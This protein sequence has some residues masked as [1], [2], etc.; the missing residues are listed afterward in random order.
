[1]DSAPATREGDIV[2]FRPGVD[3]SRVEGHLG[4]GMV[5]RM[6]DTNED[7]NQPRG[8]VMVYKSTTAS[9]FSTNSYWNTR[10]G[11][12]QMGDVRAQLVGEGWLRL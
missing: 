12:L 3:S 6:W 10:L 2:R 9:H 4:G 7:E 11:F 8:C 1:M 5:T